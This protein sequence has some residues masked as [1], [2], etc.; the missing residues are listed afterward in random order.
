MSWKI[1]VLYSL[2]SSIITDT[3]PRCRHYCEHCEYKTQYRD[4]LKIHMGIEHVDVKLGIN[5][6]EPHDQNM[7]V[8]LKTEREI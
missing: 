8:S 4:E 1:L 6:K 2:K 7:T 3:G 5:S